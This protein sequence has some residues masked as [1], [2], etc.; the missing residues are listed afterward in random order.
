[1]RPLAGSTTFTPPPCVPTLM[2]LHHAL[3][4]DGVAAAGDRVDGGG[5]AAVIVVQREAA[6]KRGDPHLV[7][8]RFG[9]RGHQL[10]SQP[11]RAVPAELPAAR[12]PAADAA[13]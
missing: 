8:G 3:I 5:F 13:R 10:V 12:I 1:M 4:A 7:I 6:S 9:E 11:G 2:E